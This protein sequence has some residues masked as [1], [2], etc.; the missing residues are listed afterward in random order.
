M[1][2]ISA[3]PVLPIELSP[4]KDFKASNF[5]VLLPSICKYCSIVFICTS[6][7]PRCSNSSFTFSM[8]ILSNLSMATVMSIILSVPPHISANA[9][10]ILRLLILISTSIPSLANTVV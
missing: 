10:N 7:K 6:F 5:S 8:P 2:S 9:A 1:Y 4:N 3:M